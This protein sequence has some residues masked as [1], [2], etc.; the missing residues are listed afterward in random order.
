MQIYVFLTASDYEKTSEA[1]GQQQPVKFQAGICIY[2]SQPKN[3][4]KEL[5]SQSGKY[6]NGM[7]GCLEYLPF[8][9]IHK[10]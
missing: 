9:H 4:I 5:F 2:P 3:K 6:K 1:L 10:N 8:L 7:N